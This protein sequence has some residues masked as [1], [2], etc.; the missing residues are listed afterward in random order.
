MSQFAKIQLYHIPRKQNV[1]VDE[2]AKRAV[3]EEVEIMLMAA[4]LQEPKLEGAESLSHIIHFM[5]E[6]EYPK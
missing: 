4:N 6:G 5:Q 2:L 3:E 1:D